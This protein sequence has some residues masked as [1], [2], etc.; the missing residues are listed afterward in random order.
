VND[1]PGMQGDRWRN[2]WG[3]DAGVR[4]AVPRLR[5]TT[6]LHWLYRVR[7][8]QYHPAGPE[9]WLDG[10]ERVWWLDSWTALTPVFDLRLGALYERISIR[11]SAV[12]PYWTWG[13][14]R[15]SRAYV[16]LSAR[17][18]NFMVSGVEGIELDHEAYDV[19]F[20]HDKGFITLQASF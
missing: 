16:G 9:Q 19:Y 7:V 14:R 17:F 13:S 20:V 12:F 10:I 5:T 15:E 11:R 3:T 2:A 8:E 1:P 6:D 4:V 18:G